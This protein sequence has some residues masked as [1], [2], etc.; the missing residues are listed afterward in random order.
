MIN[1]TQHRIGF[2]HSSISNR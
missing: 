1:L 2:T